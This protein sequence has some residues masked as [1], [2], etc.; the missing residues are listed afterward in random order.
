MKLQEAN[1]PAGTV[2][3]LISVEIL[4]YGSIPA[5]VINLE[6]RVT[7]KLYKLTMSEY[8][9]MNVLEGE[10]YK[11]KGFDE[12]I[13]PCS[14]MLMSTGISTFYGVTPAMSEVELKTKPTTHVHSLNKEVEDKIINEA[15]E[16]VLGDKIMKEVNNFKKPQPRS[17]ITWSQY[18]VYKLCGNGDNQITTLGLISAAA[19]VACIIYKL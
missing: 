3:N 4:N 11:E 6:D 13:L 14:I 18:I 19:I 1:L 12:V 15:I 5:D 10:I 2:L 8:L 16:R 9:K 7:K 17:K